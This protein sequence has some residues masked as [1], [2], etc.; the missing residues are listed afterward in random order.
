MKTKRILIF[1]LIIVLLGILA[2]FYPYLTG[3]TVSDINQEYEKEN[4]F[5]GRVIDGD[6]LIYGNQTIR[7]LGSKS[8]K[9]IR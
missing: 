9:N 1:L 2:Y 8:Y 5:V 6:T 3:E 7:L 4:C